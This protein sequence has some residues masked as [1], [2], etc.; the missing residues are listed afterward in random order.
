M[1]CHRESRSVQNFSS[2]GHWEVSLNSIANF[3]PNR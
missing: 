2:I 1:H 3:V